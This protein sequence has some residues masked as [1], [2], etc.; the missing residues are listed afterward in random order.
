MNMEILAFNEA[1]LA[2][3]AAQL[4]AAPAVFRLFNQNG[5]FT[6]PF[7]CMADILLVGG[8][9]DRAGP[10]LA[11]AEAFVAGFEDDATQAPHVPAL[12][13]QLRAVKGED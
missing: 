10:A 5:T 11:A 1:R 3:L 8:G 6:V 13:A 12:L 9:A 4:G 2:K 7:H